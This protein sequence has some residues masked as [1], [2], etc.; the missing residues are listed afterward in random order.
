[1]TIIDVRPHRGGWQVFEAPG[2]EPFYTG[3]QA[4]EYA[5]GYAN[6]RA[7]F[8]AGE[9]HVR[10]AAGGLEQVIPFA[11]SSLNQF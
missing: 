4:K 8:R 5:L 3:S 10:D 7:R 2:V 11:H 1:M 9:I 6:E